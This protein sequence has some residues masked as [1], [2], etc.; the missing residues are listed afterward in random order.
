MRLI[1]SP[2]AARRIQEISAYL[3]VHSPSAA[4]HVGD[5]LQDAFNL[6]MTYPSA[7][8]RVRTNVRRFVLKRFPY[9]IYYTADEASGTVKI[10]TV[11]HAAQAKQP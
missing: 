6:L 3:Q 5:E 11:L 9:L 2:R 8:R 7:G 4:L 1:V 10:I